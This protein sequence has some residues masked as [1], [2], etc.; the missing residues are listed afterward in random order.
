MAKKKLTGKSGK[1]VDV[2]HADHPTAANSIVITA[3]CGSTSIE[4]SHTFG[5]NDGDRLQVPDVAMLQASL[6]AARQ[7]AADEA[8]WRETMTIAKAQLV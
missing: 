6:D 5:A 3:V 4:M 8:D 2:T 7:R 1:S